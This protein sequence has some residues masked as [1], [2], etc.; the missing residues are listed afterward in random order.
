MGLFENL[1][2]KVEE[3]K[4]E[5]TEAS[6]EQ[7]AYR[8]GECGE[9]VYGGRDDCSECG[10][11]NLV[12]RDESDDGDDEDSPEDDEDSP[13]AETEDSAENDGEDDSDDDSLD[14][15]TDASVDTDNEVEADAAAEPDGDD[16]TE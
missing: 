3:F 10:S 6:R 12:P 13:D 14:G 11:E 4:Q 15:E 16:D 9:L 7:A 2:R 5:A 1:G 8:C